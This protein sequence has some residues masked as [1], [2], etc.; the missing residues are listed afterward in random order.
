[1]FVTNIFHHHIYHSVSQVEKNGLNTKS[2]YLCDV[3][4]YIIS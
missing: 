4:L 2:Y 1:M 3:K